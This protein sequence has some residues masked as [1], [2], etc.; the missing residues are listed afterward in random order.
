MRKYLISALLFIIILFTGFTPA[1]AQDNPIP[2]PVETTSL[3]Q[4]ISKASGIV[5]PLAVLGFIAMVIYAGYIRMMA[6]GSAE[7]EAKSMQI[8][9]A[10]ATGFAIIAIAPLIVRIVAKLIGV[11]TEIIQ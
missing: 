5:T 9:V 7:K 6:A 4:L 8:A 11:K 10:A 1:F 2:P 3:G